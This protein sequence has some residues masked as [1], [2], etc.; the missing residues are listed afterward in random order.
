MGR[1]RVRVGGRSAVSLGRARAGPAT[2]RP[3]PLRAGDDVV[4]DRGLLPHRRVPTRRDPTDTLARR[5]LLPELLP[6][7]LCRDPDLHARRGPAAWQPELAGQLDRRPGRRGR[8]R[9]VCVSRG[10]LDG[11]GDAPG[12]RHESRLS[13]RGPA[14][15]QPGGGW[16]GDA[17]GP[18]TAAVAAAGRRDGAE[19]GRGH[20][21]PL[22]LDGRRHPRRHGLQQLRLAGLDLH[23]LR[24]DVAGPRGRRS[25]RPTETPRLRA[26]RYRLPGRTRR[27]GR[28][29]AFATRDRWRSGW[30]RPRSSSPG[31]A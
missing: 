12:S 11:W 23:D 15:A 2:S 5:R 21:Q 4:G 22:L 16:N 14:V 6:A 8:M 13:D 3:D 7:G 10:P 19:H 30:P 29:R 9:G 28:W 27:A 25:A 17:R 18:Q 1:E 20:V 31:C 26:S 24:G